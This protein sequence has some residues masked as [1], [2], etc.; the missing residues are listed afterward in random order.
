[1]KLALILNIINPLIGG[2][3]L[4][5]EKGTAKSTTVRSLNKLLPE[6]EGINESPFFCD[7]INP[8]DFCEISR[9]MYENE[10]PFTI[11]K[12][13]MRV[14]ELPVSATEDRVVGSL[15]IEHAITH[16]KKRFEHGI[17]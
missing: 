6:V 14:V 2:V 1:M 4:K 8:R 13:Q 9:K 3:L 11:G 7:P 15:D 12:R 16:G 10:E 5:G 17:L